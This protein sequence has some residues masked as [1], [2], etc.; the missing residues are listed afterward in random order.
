M[1]G[2]EKSLKTTFII[3]Y[4]P[5][6]TPCT[7]LTEARDRLHLGDDAISV[8]RPNSHDGIGICYQ[9]KTEH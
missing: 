2:P 1:K 3:M 7:C 8:L 5:C 9:T 6:M 4:A